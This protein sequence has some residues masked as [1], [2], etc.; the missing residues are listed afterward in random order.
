MRVNKS[1]KIRNM[2]KIIFIIG[3]ILASVTMNAQSDTHTTHFP[4]GTAISVTTIGNHSYIRERHTRP[5]CIDHTAYIVSSDLSN[6]ENKRCLKF[7][8]AEVYYRCVFSEKMTSS[9]T[10]D[11]GGY[12]KVTPVTMYKYYMEEWVYEGVGYL[13]DPMDDFVPDSVY[14]TSHSGYSMYDNSANAEMIL[15]DNVL[16][17][18]ILSPGYGSC[19]LY[20]DKYMTEFNYGI[21]GSIFDNTNNM[22][23]AIGVYGF[24]SGTRPIWGKE[25]DIYDC[26]FG[27]KKPV[28]KHHS[29]KEIDE[30]AYRNFNKYMF[31]DE[32]TVDRMEFNERL[33]YPKKKRSFYITTVPH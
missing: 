6:I 31:T 33:S 22:I 8:K 11:M 15:H 18:H 32:E 30:D 1:E 24:Y 14:V 3:I 4:D 10:V 9:E 19:G 25:C 17:V 13:I 21:Y 7:D 12:T 20:S 2:K 29:K 23:H 28:L 16:S 27:M 5:D 26:C